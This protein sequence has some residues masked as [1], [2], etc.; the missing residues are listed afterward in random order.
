MF[1]RYDT[2][3]ICDGQTQQHSGI[4]HHCCN[5]INIVVNHSITINRIIKESHLSTAVSVCFKESRNL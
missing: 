2:I 1:T 3:H 5:N 4:M